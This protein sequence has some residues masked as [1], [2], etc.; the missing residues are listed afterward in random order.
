MLN[1][2]QIKTLDDDYTH[3]DW[4]SNARTLCGLETLGDGLH[5]INPGRPT[6]SRV[7]CPRCIEIVTVCRDISRN[8][9]RKEESL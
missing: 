7:D 6:L 2:I 1:H 3:F 8:E 5:G 4:L 9:Y